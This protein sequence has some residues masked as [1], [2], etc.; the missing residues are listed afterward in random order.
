MRSR[1]KRICQIGAQIV[2]QSVEN[3]GIS[4][5][6]VGRQVGVSTS[7]IFK[8]LNREMKDQFDSITTSLTFSS[9]AHNNRASRR[10]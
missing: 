5:A 1:I 2:Y 3:F 8:A 7:A 4:L 9:M 10:R 6:E